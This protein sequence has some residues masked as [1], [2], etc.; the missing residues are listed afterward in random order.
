MG[1]V[2]SFFYAGARSVLSS[3]WEVSDQ[4]SAALMRCFYGQLGRQAGKA[5]ALRQAKLSL[6]ESKYGHPFYWAG[7]ILH[8]E[9][10]SSVSALD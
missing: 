2:R 8:G 7:F 4:A 5:Q 9:P 1:L 6:L 10:F 3:L